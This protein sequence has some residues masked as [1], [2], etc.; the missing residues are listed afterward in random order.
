MRYLFLFLY[1][2]ILFLLVV[3][4]ARKR[5]SGQDFYVA[6]KSMGVIGI[7]GS[8]SATIL[9]SSAIL[10]TI[11]LSWE[12]GWASSW[13]LLCAAIGLIALLPLAGYVKRF[14]RF[15]LP[16]MLGDFYGER[17]KLI[18]SIL[19]PI[20]WI[21]IIA[22][23]M[24][25]AAKIL[26][27]F[28]NIP[29]DWGVWISGFVFITYTITGG[30]LSII[31]TDVIQA[32]FVIS[33]VFI[34]FL[35]CV[36]ALEKPVWRINTPSFPF[37][38]RFGVL[39]LIVLILTYSSTYFVGPDVYSRLFCSKNENV[40][41]RSVLLVICIMIPF[42]FILSFLGVYAKELYPALDIRSVSAL[43]H[44]VLNTLPEWGVGIMIAALL[45]A[46]MSSA[47]TTL[48]TSSAI[49]SGLFTKDMDS[50]KS[51][52][53][54]RWL[55]FIFGIISIFF[56]LKITSI[57]SSLL[58]ATTIFSGAFIIPTAAG[59]LGYRCSSTRITIA[60]LGGGIIA[61]TGKLL[62][63]YYMQSVGNYV[64]ILGLLINAFIL[65]FPLNNKG[66]ALWKRD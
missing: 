46:I 44:L 23:Q 61:F 7:A 6:G 26:E 3:N 60:M 39:D 2:L 11:N 43:V 34:T 57:I 8:L 12:Q 10:G 54:T 50:H 45:S 37:N 29:Y 20:A 47:D 28:F 66:V 65:F 1:L 14:G 21:G 17:A 41:K 22:A 49:V 19:I 31:K 42:A 32:M 15:T 55:I 53:H 24:I 36:Y 25:G 59:L 40:A 30:Q 56:A 51:V 52:K 5:K 62:A 9:G 13:I 16:Q 48:L 18:S 38:E 58:I 4:H 63:L 33:G 27:S 64:I 35:F